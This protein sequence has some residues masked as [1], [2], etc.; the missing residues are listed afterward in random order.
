MRVE[1]LRREGAIHVGALI[2]ANGRVVAVV[3]FDYIKR[4]QEEFHRGTESEEVPRGW[5]KLAVFQA[6]SMPP[7]AVPG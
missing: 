7:W 6:D 1:V 3:G 2:E 5:A 4:E